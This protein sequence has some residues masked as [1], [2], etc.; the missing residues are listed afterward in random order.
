MKF[1]TNNHSHFELHER[2]SPMTIATATLRMM[3]E[4]IQTGN[5]IKMTYFDV[6]NQFISFSIKKE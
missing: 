4:V 6:Q 3:T 1:L 2:F 5:I